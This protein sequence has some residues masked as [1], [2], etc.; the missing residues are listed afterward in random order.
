MVVPEEAATD[1]HSA[2][3]LA[4]CSNAATLASTS[5]PRPARAGGGRR[6]RLRGEAEEE[7]TRNKLLLLLLL[8]LDW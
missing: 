1:R 7:R 2:A 3:T 8:P 6:G 4:C 5:L